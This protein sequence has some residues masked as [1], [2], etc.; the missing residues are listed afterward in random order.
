[1]DDLMRARLL[2]DFTYHAAFGTQ[3]ERYAELRMQ[4]Q[5]LAFSLA[6]HCPPSRELS[7]ALTNLEQ[8]MFWGIAAIARNEK[9]LE[10]QEER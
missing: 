7:V 2:N 3:P 9:Q 10:Q 1:M 6:D 4:C 5:A 8:V